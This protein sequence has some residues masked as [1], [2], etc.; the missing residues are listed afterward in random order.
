[1]KRKV[2]I[3]QPAHDFIIV[4]SISAAEFNADGHV[5]ENRFYARVKAVGPGKLRDDGSRS[6]MSCKPGDILLVWG[7]VNKTTFEGRELLAIQDEAVFAVVTPE[8]EEIDD[9][10]ELIA[11]AT[12]ADLAAIKLNRIQPAKS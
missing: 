1:M 9:G 8:M 4:E 12:A 3:L 6:P 10:A 7:G 5:D 2:H 11:R